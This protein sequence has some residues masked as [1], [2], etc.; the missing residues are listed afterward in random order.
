VVGDLWGHT[1]CRLCFHVHESIDHL[2]FQCGFSHRIWRS[3]M[4]DCLSPSPCVSWDDVVLWA[5]SL[6]GKRLHTTLCKLG[7]AAAVYHIW[8]FA[9]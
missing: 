6:K 1:L 9:K 3:L 2:F 5:C 8:R 7:L 4:E